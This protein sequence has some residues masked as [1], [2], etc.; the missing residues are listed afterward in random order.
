MSFFSEFECQV[1]ES[2]QEKGT[3][4]EIFPSADADSLPQIEATQNKIRLHLAQ[5]VKDEE[6]ARKALSK[7]SRALLDLADKVR[8]SARVMAGQF[9][10]FKRWSD[11]RASQS[12][13]ASLRRED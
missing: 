2:K 5:Q 3:Y 6:S 11:S 4:A 1:C 7:R 10:D 13:R 12:L 9:L 8:V